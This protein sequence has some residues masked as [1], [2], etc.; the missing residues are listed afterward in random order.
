MGLLFDECLI[1]VEDSERYNEG[2]RWKME[3]EVR[4]QRKNM[5][6]LL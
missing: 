1:R 2:G 6:I 3:D 5:G 4:S